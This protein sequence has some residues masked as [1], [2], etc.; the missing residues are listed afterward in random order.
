MRG[1]EE[2]NSIQLGMVEAIVSWCNCLQ[3]Q[4]RVGEAL[5]LMAAS[6]DA[7]TAVLSRVSRQYN[8]KT[9]IITQDR[10]SDR[11]EIVVERSFARAVLQEYM[12][13]AQLG[14][15][16]MSRLAHDEMDHD[17]RHFQMRSKLGE[18]V[19]IPIGSAAKSVDFIEFHFRTAPNRSQHAALNV[20]ASNLTKTWAN[21]TPGLFSSSMPHA[22]SKL[23][24]Q[25]EESAPILS[26]K[27]PARLSRMEYRV[28][29]LLHRGQSPSELREEL[30]ISEATLRTHLRNVYSKTGAESLSRLMYQLV[31]SEPYPVAIGA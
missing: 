13:K 5:R 1:T 22:R 19:V 3:G 11:D 30:G 2:N 20:L 9:R 7:E 15:I 24:M 6:I 27:N 14:T 21:R 4:I 29:V 18:T 28:C 23:A 12:G 17:L 31:S 8:G 26:D 16:W 25:P 10:N